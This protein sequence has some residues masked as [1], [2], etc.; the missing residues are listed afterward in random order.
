MHDARILLKARKETK[1][2]IS[3]NGNI[4]TKLD[5][6]KSVSQPCFGTYERSLQGTSRCLYVSASMLPLTVFSWV[7]FFIL[8]DMQ[9]LWRAKHFLQSP[10]VLLKLPMSTVKFFLKFS[11]LLFPLSN[12]PHP[13]LE[14]FLCLYSFIFLQAKTVTSSCQILT[15]ISCMLLP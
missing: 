7:I 4:Y 11:C 5:Q 13:M 14:F 2:C 15:C 8:I 12:F 3:Y 9:H 1:T 10:L 6:F